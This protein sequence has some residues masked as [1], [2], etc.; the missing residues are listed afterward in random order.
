MSFFFG[1][2]KQPRRKGLFALAV[3]SVAIVSVGLSFAASAQSFDEQIVVPKMSIA[4][5][6]HTATLLPDGRVLVAGGNSYITTNEI[7]DPVLNQWTAGGNLSIA[8]IGHS[9]TLLPNGQVLV[10]GGRYSFGP[11]LETTR[12][13]LYD[14]ATGRWR[15]AST[16]RIGRNGHTATLLQDGTLLVAGGDVGFA[17]T[18]AELYSAATGQWSDTGNMSTTR[19]GHTATLLADGRVL[20]AGGSALVKTAEI[21]D[22]ATGEWGATGPMEEQHTAGTATLLPDGRVLVLGVLSYGGIPYPP[23]GFLDLPSTEIYSATTNTW[24]AGAP[25]S[26]P[27]WGHTA[28]M[29][30]DGKLIIIGG[31]SWYGQALANVEIFD[32][33]SNRWYAA[34]PLASPRAN[35]TA[36]LLAD[37][38]ILVVGG[39]DTGGAANTAERY[40]PA[41]AQ[42]SIQHYLSSFIRRVEPPVAVPTFVPA[43]PT[44]TPRP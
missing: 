11:A 20:V 39:D 6:G 17:T 34:R 12:A 28:T 15:M 33:A 35:H 14:P 36:T 27:R 43:F 9:A 22:P 4:R 29:L 25:M 10:L 42:L 2:L 5:S 3:S 18:T 30:P 37:G 38:T 40:N 16:T 44:P 19:F 31:Y 7:Y 41:D 8:R 1:L 24:E 26:I 21:Y 23:P 13:E 32:S